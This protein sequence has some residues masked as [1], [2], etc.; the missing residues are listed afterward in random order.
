MTITLQ[1][2]TG[3]FPET[4]KLLKVILAVGT[5][6]VE[7]SSSYVKLIKTRIRNSI[8]D[9][10]LGRLMRIA[11]E[12]PELLA[13]NFDKVLEIF[14]QKIWKNC[15]LIY[16]KKK[17]KKNCS[18]LPFIIIIKIQISWEREGNSRVYSPLYETLLAY[19]GLT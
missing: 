16:I 4:F 1:R 14:K 15:A 10:T 19:P 11:I 6:S 17:L 7:R 12:G 13:V 3:I 5:T 18:E 9:Q 8:T 2:Y